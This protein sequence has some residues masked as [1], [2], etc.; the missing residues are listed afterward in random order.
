ML[1]QSV[2]KA[3]DIIDCLSVEKEPLSASEVARRCDLSRPTAYRLL[4]SLANKNFVVSPRDGHFTLGPKFLSISKN[5]LDRY[6]LIE[7]AKPHMD[8]LSQLSGE[9]VHLTI[10]D[11]VEMLYIWKV[12][13]QQSIRMH[14]SIGTR[15]PVYSTATGKAVLASLPI[16]ELQQVIRHIQFTSR[17]ANTITTQEE[18][19]EALETV[20]H[21]KYAIDDLE[22]EEGI[23]CV[24]APIFG[25]SGKVVGGLSV[26]GPAYRLGMDRLIELSKYVIATAAKIS[27][28]SGYVPNT[29]DEKK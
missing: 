17:T 19:I 29:G 3:L 1:I 2:S 13:S 4:I 25:L 8:Q 21:K 10:L 6:D 12:D 18:L 14:A 28:L 24:A 20:R 11:G 5:L 16:A 23:R 26:S 27:H 7:I 22:N 9:T 15:N